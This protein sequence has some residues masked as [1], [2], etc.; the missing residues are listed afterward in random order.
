MHELSLMQGVLD[1]I[2]PVALENGATAVTCITLDIGEMTQVVEEAMQFAFDA[3][4][5]GEELF[6][7]AELVMNFIPC[8]SKCF[9]CGAEFSHD[10]YHMKC[11]ECASG[12]TIVVSGKEMHIA[13]IEI[14][15]GED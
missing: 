5:E 2:K 1:S 14:E 15:N 6:D 8:R 13:S 10:R 11:P 7:G 4:T 3:L 9:E 12:H